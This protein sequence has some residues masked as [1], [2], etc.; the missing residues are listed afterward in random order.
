MKEIPPAL[1]YHYGNKK[2][3]MANVEAAYSPLEAKRKA[4]K[5]IPD[6]Y[7]AI[8]GT[9]VQPFLMDCFTTGLS[10]FPVILMQCK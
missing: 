5:T 2:V 6:I 7:Q 4:V 9:S 1:V 8:S 3:K 10:R